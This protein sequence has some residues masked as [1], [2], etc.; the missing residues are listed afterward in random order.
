[1]DR[2]YIPQQDRTAEYGTIEF[3]G[4]HFSFAIG[5]AVCVRADPKRS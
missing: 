4:L 1:M 5:C 3:V 2:L